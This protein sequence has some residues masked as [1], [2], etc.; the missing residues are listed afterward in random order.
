MQYMS[1]K[2]AAKKW[3]I[4]QRHVAVLRS[5][6]RIPNAAILGNMWLI[7]K[8]ASKPNDGRSL[9]YMTK[10]AQLKPFVKWAGGKGQLINEIRKIYPKELGKQINKYAEPFVGGGAVLFDI[11]SNYNLESIYI[12]DI[13]AELINAYQV[14]R[15]DVEGLIGLLSV[16]QEEY[17]HLDTESR[18]ASYYEKRK[19][20]ND[21]KIDGN[22]TLNIEKAA[23]FIFLNKTCFNG[24]YRVNRKGLFNVPVGAYKSP[25]ICDA[26][27]LR[28]I[29]GAL[30]N[31][32]IVCGDFEES[33]KFIDQNTFVYFDPPYRPLSD[34]SSFTAYN[35]SS[36]DDSEQIRL[37]R[38]AEEMSVRGAK[39]VISN[40]DP[41]NTSKDDSF[42]DN[43]YSSFNISRVEASRMI[44][45]DGDRRGKI[46]ELLIAN[47]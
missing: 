45:S 29:S 9:R 28:N 13:N 16:M 33:R 27:N 41:K 22:K 24:L 40:S 42:F 39:I 35:E 23:L 2:E 19:R 7:P 46:N 8:D 25:C 30:H 34:T 31:V 12:S 43:L 32:T 36:F 37:A 26:D 18:K 14:I 44:N 11:L 3:N 38:F 10:K 20:Y 4:S 21:I 47:Y 1:A 5:E 17:T 15:D 6:G